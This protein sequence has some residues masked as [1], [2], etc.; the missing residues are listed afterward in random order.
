MKVSAAS[1]ADGKSDGPVKAREDM[2]FF[3]ACPR[4]VRLVESGFG[5]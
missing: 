1:T 2:L 3:A 4:I 5:E